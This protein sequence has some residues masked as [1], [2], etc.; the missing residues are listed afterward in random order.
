MAA[1][2]IALEAQPFDLAFHP[3]SSLVAAGTITGT[4]QL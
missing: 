2:D 1:L 4:L 3:T